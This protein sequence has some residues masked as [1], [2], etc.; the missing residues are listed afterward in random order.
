M[1]ISY[2][3]T[4]DVG[5]M[6][7]AYQVVRGLEKNYPNFEDWY[8]NTLMTDVVQG[9]GKFMVARDKDQIIGITAAKIGIE[10]KIRCIR[11]LEQYKNRG[12]AIHLL[13]RMLKFTGDK[14]LCTVPETML[15]DLSRILI[16]RFNFDLSVVKKGVYKP[17]VLEYYFN[18][19][20]PT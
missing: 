7:I 4:T 19:E 18:Y 15:H 12:I 1:S 6:L 17:G 3:L 11:I 20:E 14:P 16:N 5:D 8:I 2:S 10:N 9:S 13:D